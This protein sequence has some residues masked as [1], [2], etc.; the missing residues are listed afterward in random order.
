MAEE[1][2][3]PT[4]HDVSAALEGDAA[5]C[6]RLV[7]ALTPIIQARVVRCIRVRRGN[8]VP[9]HRAEVLD[10]V[11]DVLLHLFE[12]NCRV[13]R[14]WDPKRAS[15]ATFVGLVAESLARSLLR[16]GK[17]TGRLEDPFDDESLELV[18]VPDS[19]EQAMLDRQFLQALLAR[20]ETKLGEKRMRLFRRLFVEE[21][22]TEE[23]AAEFEM[24]P[25]AIYSARSRLRDE[26]HAEAASM[27][28]ERRVA[29]GEQRR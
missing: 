27:I 5:A 6:E 15:L 9:T 11:Q 12:Q 18:G 3:G 21:R 16:T 2:A 8:G 20:L 26:V 13:L 4:A 19:F 28:A 10:L 1:S 25:N 14:R 24:S 22:S 7:F 23:V 29:V 17:R